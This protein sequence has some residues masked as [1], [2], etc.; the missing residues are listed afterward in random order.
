MLNPGN[1]SLRNLQTSGDELSRVAPQAGNFKHYTRAYLPWIRVD[2]A[3]KMSPSHLP[4]AG[5]MPLV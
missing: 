2:K 3:S 4:P 1:K 5:T